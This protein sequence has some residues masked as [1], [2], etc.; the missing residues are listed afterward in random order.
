M[1]GTKSADKATSSQFWYLQQ[2]LPTIKT[3][4]RS[5][6]IQRAQ[7]ELQFINVNVCMTSFIT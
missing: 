7:H 1:I 6:E 2:D 4:I 3:T 5:K